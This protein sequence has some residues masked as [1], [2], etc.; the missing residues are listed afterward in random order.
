MNEERG[1]HKTL[2]TMGPE[3][4][5]YLFALSIQHWYITNNDNG[6]NNSIDCGVNMSNGRATL[7]MLVTVTSHKQVIQNRLILNWMWNGRTIISF[8]SWECISIACQI[9][10]TVT[11]NNGLQECIVLPPSIVGWTDT[12]TMRFAYEWNTY[13]Y[14]YSVVYVI[15]FSSLYWLY[16]VIFW[17][18]HVWIFNMI[19]L[20]ILNIC[21]YTD[22]S[23]IQIRW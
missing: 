3:T 1:L 6:H 19:T 12:I 21:K 14:L 11:C 22:I 23:L 13:R 20:Q 18:F 8:E 2:I 5:A 7:K 17:E 9:T 15:L 16:H 10:I 4:I